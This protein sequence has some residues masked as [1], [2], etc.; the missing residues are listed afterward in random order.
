MRILDRLLVSGFLKLFLAT[1]LGAPF[2][3]YLGDATERMDDYLDRGVEGGEIALAYLFMYPKFVVWAFPIAALVAAVFTIHSMTVHREIVAAKA[4]GIS[5][6]RIVAPLVVLG[7][8]LTGLAYFLSDVVPLT[9]RTAA[10]LLGEREVRRGWRSDFVFQGEDGRTVSARRLSV[11]EGKLVGVVMEHEGRGTGEPALHVMAEEAVWD[12][13]QGWTFRRG[14]LRYIYP[15]GPERVF[16][17]DRLRAS[18]FDERPIDLLEDPRDDEQMTYAEIDRLASVM[19]RSGGDPSE[20]LVEKEQRR[21]LT[22]TT[23]VIILFGAPLATSSKRGGTAYGIGISLGSTIL[24]LV[25]FRLAE[26]F[27]ANGALS[28]LTAAW[29][30]NGLFFVTGV[31][32]LARVRT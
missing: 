24:Y 12:S 19:R 14:Q 6:Y 10:E 18:G 30:P 16:G 22:V 28:P 4:G 17:F 8:A 27:G 26:A 13:A 23:L 5:F 9:N 31:V 21:A 32:L 29:L 25:L 1:S 15:E 3:F 2:L 7:T 20:L 11:E